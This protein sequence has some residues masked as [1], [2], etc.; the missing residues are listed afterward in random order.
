MN[1][2]NVLRTAAV[3]CGIAGVLFASPAHCS[4]ASSSAT[5]EYQEPAAGTGNDGVSGYLLKTLLG[6]A[7]VL[8]L[9]FLMF[10]GY[11]RFVEPRLGATSAHP[12]AVHIVGYTMLG[13][14]ASIYLVRTAGK[15]LVVGLT[16]QSM[17]CLL[18]TS[19]SPRDS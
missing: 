8:G 10:W 18:Y 19:P 3:A 15:R 2:G 14:R 7:F 16:Q 9:F 4:T 12:G 17:V 13:P 11:R 1:T 6:L 5:W